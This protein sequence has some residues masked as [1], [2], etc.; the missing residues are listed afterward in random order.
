MSARVDRIVV[1]PRYTALIGAASVF[2]VPMDV[3]AYARAAMVAWQ[4]QGIGTSAAEVAFTTQQSPDL[5]N[6]F[7][8]DTLTPDAN[9]EDTATPE[10]RYP[11]FRVK[12]TV[13]G[14]DPGV[15][16]WLV[17]EFV[18]REGAGG[19]GAA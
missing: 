13:T 16:C 17:G 10:L 18:A 19:G 12:A 7:D 9:E 5:E 1:F 6:W 2:T 14:S 3:R 11:W 15:T 8:G 4:S